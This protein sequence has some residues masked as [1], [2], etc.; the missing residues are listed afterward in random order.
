MPPDL[1]TAG[2]GAWRWRVM[3]KPR[4]FMGRIYTGRQK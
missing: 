4:K 3:W 1:V 2:G